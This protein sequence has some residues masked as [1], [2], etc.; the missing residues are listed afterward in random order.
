LT[1]REVVTY[2]ATSVRSA[3]RGSLGPARSAPAGRATC[4]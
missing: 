3:V 1:L 4:A 2:Q